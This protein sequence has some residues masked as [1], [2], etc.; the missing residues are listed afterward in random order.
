MSLLE[1]AEE[2]LHC[3]VALI[4]FKL[5]LP[6]TTRKKCLRDFKFLGF[7][8]LSPTHSLCPAGCNEYMFMAYDIDP[9]GES[10]SDSD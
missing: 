5:S 6:D 8:L 2:V 3:K 4:F 1:H 7:E 9:G 10:G